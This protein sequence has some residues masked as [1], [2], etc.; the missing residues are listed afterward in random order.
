MLDPSSPFLLARP[1]GPESKNAICLKRLRHILVACEIPP[2][3][4]FSE[5][6]LEARY[7]LSRASIRVAL[8][9]LA[10]EGLVM[11]QPRQGWKAAPLTGASIG[12]LLSARRQIEHHLAEDAPD[13]PVVEKL[14]TLAMFNSALLGRSDQQSLVTARATDRQILDILAEGKGFF[15]RKW[16]SEVWDQSARVVHFLER[17]EARFGPADRRP[18]VSALRSKDRSA[19]A[20]ELLGEIDRFHDFVSDALLRL[21][22]PLAVGAERNLAHQRTHWVAAGGA[23]TRHPD[24][25]ATTSETKGNTT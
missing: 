22:L 21:R 8:A 6:E 12:D 14:D 10:A 4:S 13:G 3:C 11:S 9:S 15:L 20:A 19:A 25:P 18:L 17:P 24:R 16:L 7:G 2:G 5:S 1:P 23:D